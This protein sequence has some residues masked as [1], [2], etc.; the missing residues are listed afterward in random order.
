MSGEVS[1]AAWISSR[2]GRAGRSL[3]TAST[4]LPVSAASPAP[5]AGGGNP[6]SRDPTGSMIRDDV[7]IPYRFDPEVLSAWGDVE[8]EEPAAGG[9]RNTVWFARVN[10]ARCVVRRS[11]RP[12]AAVEWELDIVEAV[13]RE[14]LGV[15]GVV[16]T[17]TGERFRGDVVIHEHVEGHAPESPSDWS[18]VT[19]YLTALHAAFPEVEQRPGFLSALDLLSL[20]EGGD[21]DLTAMPPDAVQRCRRAWTRL[22]GYPITLVH[23]DPG[24]GNVLMT[25]SG[26]V[27]VDWDESR[28]DVPLFD[29]AALP[30]EVAPID[31]HE[32]W[33]ASQ[34][35][36]AWEAAVSWRAEPA[37]ARRRLAELDT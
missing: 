33:I 23:G 5:P 26:V 35:A 22:V 9:V 24:D 11:T 30:A 8:L 28:V 19:R 6:R 32:R 29:L 37:Y 1:N 13:R 27:L 31:D 4:S 34:A 12:R 17:L 10:G 25:D 20:D 15:P 3:K 14:G 16:R 36:S 7:G 2:P 18:D 21:A